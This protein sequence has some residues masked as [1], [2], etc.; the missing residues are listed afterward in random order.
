MYGDIQTLWNPKPCQV[1]PKFD[2]TMN[3]FIQGKMVGHI[4]SK[5]GVFNCYKFDNVKLELQP[6]H[7]QHQ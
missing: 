3:I 7:F 2:K 1:L 4:L 6:F 5:E